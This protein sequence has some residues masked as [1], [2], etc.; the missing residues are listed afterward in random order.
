[1]LQ[2]LSQ[3]FA[4]DDPADQRRLMNASVELM[5]G[6]AATATALARLPASAAHPEVNA[7]LTFAVP[8]NLGFRPVGVARRRLFLER[9]LELRAGA[10]RIFGELSEES[11][12]KLQRRLDNAV[13]LL[14]ADSGA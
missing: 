8:R 5:E 10:Q 6:C 4:C 2:L 11:R 7:G 12:E 3:T 14:G 9:A 1:M 13:E